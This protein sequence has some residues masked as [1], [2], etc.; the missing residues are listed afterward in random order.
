MSITTTQNTDS[1]STEPK[2]QRGR[3]KGAIREVYF[4]LA[5]IK[6]GELIQEMV[7]A[8]RVSGENVSE[9]EMRNETR[10]AFYKK[11]KVEADS[12]IGPL[13][14][15]KL[16]QSAVKK[17]ETIRVPES[18]L[19]FTGH[20]IQAEYNGW[21]VIGRYYLGQ[22]GQ[23][24]DKSVKIFFEKDVSQ[25]DKPRAKPAATFKAV[26]ELENIKQ[27]KSQMAHS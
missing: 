27:L 22:D 21:E 3:P 6:D 9:D 15:A 7:H 26:S 20:K 23:E 1:N 8:P 24:N 25:G 12:E 4:C 10:K 11:H 13:F 16:T 19:E 2:K 18:E 17:R 5:A 14:E